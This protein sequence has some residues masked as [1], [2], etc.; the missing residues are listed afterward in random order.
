MMA[1]AVR[2]AHYLPCCDSDGG[3]S[4]PQKVS[5]EATQLAGMQ[6]A[7]GHPNGGTTCFL[8]DRV[9][10]IQD[11]VGPITEDVQLVL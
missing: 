5:Y 4:A 6:V 10:S 1:D 7:P 11:R 8:H 2:R 3:L 9:D